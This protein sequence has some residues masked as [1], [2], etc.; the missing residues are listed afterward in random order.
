MIKNVNSTPLL[1]FRGCFTGFIEDV[2]ATE[3][4]AARADATRSVLPIGNIHI[5]SLSSSSMDYRA[6]I[7]SLTP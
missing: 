5:K 3:E 6:V 1:G 2:N 7:I 4:E